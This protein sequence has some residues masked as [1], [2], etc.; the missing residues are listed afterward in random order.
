METLSK[1]ILDKK[2]N[3]RAEYQIFLFNKCNLS[4]GFCFI[5]ADKLKSDDAGL[6]TI[7]F[8]AFDLI[9]EIKKLEQSK[10]TS[11]QYTINIMGGELFSDFVDDKYLDQYVEYCKIIRNEL[12]IPYNLDIEYNFISNLIY[13]NTERVISCIN[14]IRALNIKISLGTSYDFVGR[15]NKKNK[16]L[17]MDNLKKIP[18]N[19]CNSISIVLTKQNIRTL[20]KN[21]DQDFK[22]LYNQKYSLYFDHYSPDSDNKSK[23]FSPSDTDLYNALSFLAINYPETY[24]IKDMIENE[25]NSMSC[26]RSIVVQETSACG[27]CR[28]L[29]CDKN[30]FSFKKDH[31]KTDNLDIED[32]FLQ[33]YN[34][35]SCKYFKKCPLSCFLLSSYKSRDSWPTCVYKKFFFD[36][37]NNLLS[38][39]TF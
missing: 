27:N 19:I 11:K 37:E 23:V 34:C 10:N 9:K 6:K 21:N 24:P 28:N 20:I 7:I 12:E 8:Q 17:F 13:T 16:E 29:V 32:A 1:I 15:F 18:R 4:C 25:Y 39:N 14:K 36:Q 31:S 33:K 2:S 26:R 35:V 30:E 3:P 22:D 5:P 38:A